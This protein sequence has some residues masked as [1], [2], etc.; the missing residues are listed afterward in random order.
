[1]ETQTCWL[2]QV[3]IQKDGVGLL[4]MFPDGTVKSYSSY[5]RMMN[6][7][8]AWAKRCTKP[9]QV[10]S[11]HIVMYNGMNGHVYATCHKAEN[12]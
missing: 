10:S 3:I 11:T 4:A 8:K 9:H 7:V 6:G 2:G 12:V 5:A 1:M